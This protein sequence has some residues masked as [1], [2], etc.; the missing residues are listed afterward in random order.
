MLSLRPRRTAL[1]LAAVFVGSVMEGLG[2]VS[3]LPLLELLN[4]NSQ[5][6]NSRIFGFFRSFF[7]FLNVELCL[8]AVLLTIVILILTKSV[9]HFFAMTYVGQ[10][11]IDI[12]TEL[13]LM[14]VRSIF[15]A[16]WPFYIN[17]SIGK[18]VNTVSVEAASATNVYSHSVQMLA[19]ILQVAVLL[20]LASQVSLVMVVVALL[21][22]VM[23]FSGLGY[24]LDVSQRTGKQLVKL[25]QSTTAVMSETLQGIKPIKAMNSEQRLINILERE[26]VAIRKSMFKQMVAQQVI[27]EVREPFVVIFAVAGMYAA[28]RYYAVPV[29]ELLVLVLLFH[30][31]ISGI[32]TIQTSY[33]KVLSFEHNYWSVA[34]FFN[35]ALQES[36]VETGDRQP[37]LT[38]DIVFQNV[39]FAFGEKK[40]LDDVSFDI[41]F[42]SFTVLIGRSGSGKTT[43]TDLL[44]G[45]LRPA[46]GEIH[47]DGTP[48]SQVNI[49]AWRQMIGYVPQEVFLFHDSVMANITL[50]DPQVSA[51][52]V[53][54][55]LRA[56]GAWQFVSELPEGMLTVIGER[57]TK[58][59]GGQRQRLSISRALIRKPALLI[60]DEATAALDRKTEE[61]ILTTMKDLTGDMTILAISHQPVMLQAAD[62]VY[63]LQDNKIVAAAEDS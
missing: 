19:N 41:P 62:R 43:I 13:R 24:F 45:L 56:A 11:M 53:E 57:G 63:R 51:A 46:A 14:L 25:L 44:C 55:A 4:P 12:T 36:E 30:R 3:V 34:S 5:Q 54:R 47:I 21:I 61:E 49:H 48:L 16:R 23:M 39:S 8:G 52:D 32:N 33:Q 35:T 20:F 10:V 7:H 2:L 15:A 40:V 22:A 28:I 17:Q 59:S 58:L 31:A 29:S 50:G 9:L 38:K 37:R 60:L 6:V 18:L 27:I 1:I 42:Q 26:L